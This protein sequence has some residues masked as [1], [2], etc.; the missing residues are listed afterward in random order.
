MRWLGVAFLL[1]SNSVSVAQSLSERIA[2][3]TDRPEYKHGRW[4]I[5]VVDAVDGTVV[6]ERSPDQIFVPASTAKLFSCAA[7]I[8]QLGA[9]YRFKTRVVADG[10]VVNGVVNGNLVLIAS[11]DPTMGGRTKADG[12]MAF[13]NGDHTY[14]DSASITAGV[15]DTDP[16]A[17]LKDLARQIRQAGVT[18]I[19]GDVMIDDRLFDKAK[20][21]GSGPD[22]V[23]PIVINDNV[24]DFV[25]SVKDGVAQVRARPEAS[26]I[27]VESHVSVNGLRPNV[28]VTSHSEWNYTVS[29]NVPA[30]DATFVRM[31]PVHDP[32][33]FARLLFIACLK[34]EGIEVTSDK[35]A[36]LADAILLPNSQQL[37]VH[38]SPPLSELVKVTLMVSHNLYGS[39]MP[40]IVTAN[41]KKRTAAEGL[42]I[43]GKFLHELGVDKNAFAFGG[44]AGGSPA[45][46]TSPRAT[47]SLLK[48]LHGNPKFNAIEDGLPI[49]GVDGTLATIGVDSSA[50]GQVRGKTGTLFYRDEANGRFL[51]RSKSLAGVMTAKNGKTLVF[52]MFVN[53]VPLPAG[54][55]AA[56]EGAVLGQICEI[57]YDHAP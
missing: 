54:V 36:T 51:L 23:S 53:D 8:G 45:D 14:A 12:T 26:F 15:T 2:A 47:V 42:A 22:I 3:V 48:L 39:T 37:A 10:T 43:Q 41:A 7:A 16:L 46:S 13:V 5:L 52:A 57:I 55:T 38:V 20:S 27:H 21:S 28:T 35:Q 34:K 25:I 33:A 31:I 18:A 50:K 9:D 44:G 49:L 4:G 40:C 30:G 24:V 1:L 17:G 19:R 29:G 32:V 6:Y 56:R 11:G